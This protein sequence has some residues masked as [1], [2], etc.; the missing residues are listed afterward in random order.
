MFDTLTEEQKKFFMQKY[1]AKIASTKNRKDKNGNPIEFKMSFEEYVSLYLDGNV[2]PSRE[3]VLARN[4]DIGHYE[5][6]N[7]AVVHMLENVCQ[8]LGKTTEL[9]RSINNFCIAN[10]Y[11]R[12]TVKN[13]IK[14]GLLSL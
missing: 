7:V 8:T 2:I 4:N 3:Y 9:D 13:L 6:G 5:I 14:R 1:K 10:K 12:S 11:S